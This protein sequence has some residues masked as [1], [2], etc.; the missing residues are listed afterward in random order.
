M[1]RCKKAN[2]ITVIKQKHIIVM[3]YTVNEA[4]WNYLLVSNVLGQ[5]DN[6]GNEI[7]TCE[8]NLYS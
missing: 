4:W 2:K 5:T 6:I 7:G 1:E 8:N 3:Q